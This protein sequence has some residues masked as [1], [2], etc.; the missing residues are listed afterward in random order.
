MTI[1]TLG[2]QKAYQSGVMG[3]IRQFVIF[4]GPVPTNK[5][6]LIAF[7]EIK[8]TVDDE[9]IFGKFPSLTSFKN[10]AHK[11]SSY[12]TGVYAHYGTKTNLTDQLTH[13]TT[14]VQPAHA[15][16]ENEFVVFDNGA[17]GDKTLIRIKKF[18]LPST[19]DAQLTKPISVLQEQ[20]ELP[21]PDMLLLNA[22]TKITLS[23]IYGGVTFS[24]DGEYLYLTIP[25]RKVDGVTNEDLAVVNFKTAEPFK[26]KDMTYHSGG[27]ILNKIKAAFSTAGLPNSVKYSSGFGGVSFQNGKLY[28]NSNYNKKLVE[29]DMTTPH[30]LS[31]LTTTSL[32]TP[33]LDITS[34]SRYH[35]APMFLMNG[36]YF[37]DGATITKLSTPYNLDNYDGTM[38]NVVIKSNV[39]NLNYRYASG[40]NK[41]S[42]NAFRTCYSSGYHTSP[43]PTTID[44]D[45]PNVLIDFKPEI[46]LAE[47]NTKNYSIITQDPNT[48][49]RII[50]WQGGVLARLSPRTTTMT[51]FAIELGDKYQGNTIIVGTIGPTGSGADMEFST[52][53][54][55]IDGVVQINSLTFNH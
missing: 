3:Q 43:I 20:I 35:M 6:D 55:S 52:N 28:F 41:A 19:S 10:N 29:I 1:E 4:D 45:N 18:W 11:T 25:Q 34:Y 22:S 31:T 48:G 39:D 40:W 14:L 53:D 8:G 38:D 21:I 42:D 13:A 44:K 17:A 16:S 36:R 2:T 5:N 33:P 15:G 30:D 46:D 24:D 32:Y 54:I 50:E 12:Q 47:Y 51:H 9:Y 23:T 27:Y 37:M 49:K 26:L 7:S